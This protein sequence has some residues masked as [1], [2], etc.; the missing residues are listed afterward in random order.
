MIC[1]KCK[2]EYFEEYTVCA[3][4]KVELVDRIPAIEIEESIEE[5]AD[6]INFVFLKTANDLYEFEMLKSL[7]NSY[8]IPVMKNS[9]EVNQYA[10]ISIGNSFHGIELYVP[11]KLARYADKILRDNVEEN[12]VEVAPEDEYSEEELREISWKRRRLVLAI[13]FGPLFIVIIMYI[14][15]RLM[16]GF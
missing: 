10:E 13:I 15:T 12:C 14:I 8:N 7:L 1:P 3:D 2:A 5:I 9:R 4:C 6:S 16:N 11:A